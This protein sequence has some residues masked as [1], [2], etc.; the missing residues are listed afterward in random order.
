MLIFVSEERKTRGETFVFC[1]VR[2][3][4]SFGLFVCFFRALKKKTNKTQKVA[5]GGGEQKPMFLVVCWL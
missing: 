1:R 2:V 4:E 5:G 3:G